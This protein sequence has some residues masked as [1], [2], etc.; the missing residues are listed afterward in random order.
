MEMLQE[1]VLLQ[2]VDRWV[3]S[4][5]L[6][7]ELEAKLSGEKEEEEK[8]KAAVRAMMAS[9]STR[10]ILKRVRTRGG[11]FKALLK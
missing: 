6:L 5:D 8:K 10:G 9:E 3:T 2:E 4:Y 11:Q 1:I 7:M